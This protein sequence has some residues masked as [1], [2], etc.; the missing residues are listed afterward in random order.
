MSAEAFERS[1]IA[2]P[3]TTTPTPSD[4]SGSSLQPDSVRSVIRRIRFSGNDHVRNRT[5]RTLIRSRTNREMLG[6]PGLPPW[7]TIHQLT[8]GRFGE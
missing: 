7:Y 4:I 5:L 2:V 1:R 8:G 3:S 6:I